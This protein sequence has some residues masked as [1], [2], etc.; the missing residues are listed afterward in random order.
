VRSALALLALLGAVLL[1]PAGGAQTPAHDLPLF[2]T[3]D[4]LEMRIESNIDVLRRMRDEDAEEIEGTIFAVRPDGRTDILPVELRTRGNTRLDR[5]TCFFPPLRLNVRTRDME[6]TVFEGQDKI[7]L[8][9][10]CRPQGEYEQNTVEEYL[11]YRLYNLVTD[12][13]FRVR[14]A[15]ITYVDI[16]G[17][18]SDVTRYGFLIESDEHLA[19]RFGG[20]ILELEALRPEIYDPSQAALLALFQYMIGNTDWSTYVFHNAELL[21]ISPGL[22]LPVPYDFDWTGLVD[23]DYARPDPQFRIGS[24]RQRLYRGFC[25]TNVAFEPLLQRYRDAREASLAMVAEEA[26]LSEDNR[27]KMTEYLQEFYDIIDDPGEVQDKILDACREF[28]R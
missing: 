16:D 18:D 22:H 4:V 5:N 9:T 6:G 1:P 2:A 24:V 17:G 3:H 19:E 21:R 27:R 11:A 25:R 14:L 8:V 20:R 28:P 26:A 15:R 12:I 23:A 13:S 7:K 10:H